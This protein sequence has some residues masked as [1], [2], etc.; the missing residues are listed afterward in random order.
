[1][2]QLKAKLNESENTDV[3]R[4]SIR[5]S[6]LRPPRSQDRQAPLDLLCIKPQNRY[7]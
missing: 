6:A 7:F 5:E 3:D 1:L 4:D 2:I